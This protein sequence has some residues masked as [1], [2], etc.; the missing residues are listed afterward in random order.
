[1]R[2]NRSPAVTGRFG[3]RAGMALV[4]CVLLADWCRAQPPQPPNGLPNPR[5]LAIAPCG[6]RA[7]TTLEVTFT[8]QDIEESQGLL[9]SHPGLRAE[10]IAPPPPPPPD[11][12]KPAAKP[13][14][15]APVSKFKVTIAADAPLGIH[16]VRLINK[17]GI[18]NPRAFVVGDLP[19]VSEK[20]PNNDV[21][22]AQRLELNSTVHGVI[23]APTDVDYFVFSG[24]KG[25]R[26]TASCLTSSI[27]SRLRAALELYDAAGQPLAFNRHY[28]N[29][30]ALLDSTLPA[31]GDYFIRLYEFTHTQGSVEHFYRLS[32]TTTPWIDAIYPPVVEPGKS[33]QVTIF[34]RNLPNG[35]LDPSAV[36]D[37]R[38][39]EKTTVTLVGPQDALALQHLGFSGRVAPVTSVLDGFEY[40]LRSPA[41]SSNP[42]LVTYARAP[43]VL[44]NEANDT[45]ETAQEITLPCEIA[46][47]IEKRRDRDWYAF[48]AKK[49]E[50]YTLEVLSERLGTP[51][52]LYALLRRAD[53]KQTLVDL[54]DTA[55]SLAPVKF[56]TRST[57]PPTYRFVVPADGKYQ[58]LV[59]SRD[60]DTRA[61]PHFLYRVRIA[62]E[63]PDFRLIVMPPADRR[64]DS[65]CVLQGGNEYYTVLAWRQEGWNGEVALTVEGLPPGITCPPQTIGS[66]LK[67]ATLV[68]SAAADAPIWTGEIKVKG[69]ALIAG[70]HV[71]REAR[72]ASVTWPT[73]EQQNIPTVSRLDRSLVLAVREKAPFQLTATPD[74]SATTQGSKVTVTLKVARLWPD[75]K[76]PLQITALDPM[77]NLLFNNNQPLT[78]AADKNE[79]K[80]VFDVR[81]GAAL[82]TYNLVLRAQTQMPYNKDPTAKQ[83][84]NVIIVQPSVPIAL[85]VL[86]QQVA[87]LTVSN[88]N[89]M[90]KLGTPTELVV[91][92]A[93]LHNFMG[94]FKVQLVLPE[95]VKGVQ[96][97]EV[98]IPA[99]M[100]E[101]KLILTVQPDAM[102]GSRPDLIVRAIAQQ[103]GN[104]PTVHDT[105][106]NVNV[107]K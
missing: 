102:P 80:A 15:P 26:V 25:Q 57:D 7:G 44:D 48:A 52:D 72:P 12:S 21:P 23:A 81:T 103:N 46:G 85:T 32:L 84:P 62:P 65:C 93:R 101:A 70:Q 45:P 1:M 51:V 28:H 74:K 86:P 104:V 94:E 33:T 4:A 82:G 30:D 24:K 31:D 3:I 76:A 79:A 77:P 92:V 2:A 20:E 100:N 6:G 87:T 68:V 67:Q 5:L 22:Q 19:E 41:G 43:V 99:G 47:R 64:P 14:A 58:L 88:S 105:K 69:T 8:G 71:E 106:I 9:F 95:N 107:V 75:L 78:V 61:G 90:L 91:K 83:K 96:A 66:G 97:E 55:D 36:I 38:V 73:Q 89:P 37:G 17:W 27:D 29:N 40:R 35:Q 13:A 34:G 98:S 42:F 50:V 53:T 11:P 60:A 39:L 56:F 10:P 18:S 49:G 54:D 63:R 59:S 16:D